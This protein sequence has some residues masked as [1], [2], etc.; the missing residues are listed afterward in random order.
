MGPS[1]RAG[2]RG[3]TGLPSDYGPLQ[4]DIVGPGP[5]T[6]C[7]QS[8]GQESGRGQNYLLYTFPDPLGPLDLTMAFYV[9]T[10][11]Q[12]EAISIQACSKFRGKGQ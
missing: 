6:E 2:D 12:V 7:D 4:I 3:V 10:K 5:A 1:G 8:W 11:Y 9:Q